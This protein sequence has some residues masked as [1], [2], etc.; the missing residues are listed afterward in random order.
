[1]VRVDGTFASFVR[2]AT[3]ESKPFFYTKWS[4]NGQ[5]KINDMISC[6]E[7]EISAFDIFKT[8]SAFMLIGVGKGPMIAT[9]TTDAPSSQNVTKIATKVAS[10]VSTAVFSFAKTFIWG[11]EQEEKKEPVDPITQVSIKHD[12]SDP[13]REIY[14][15]DADITKRYAV[16]SDHLGRIMILDIQSMTLIH[17]IKGHREA[18]CQW[19]YDG[20]RVWLVVYAPLR[21]ILETYAFEG[22]ITRKH[23]AHVGLEKLMLITP[24]FIG[25][26]SQQ[27][28]P[29]PEL[30]MLS[31]DGTLEKIVLTDPTS[32]NTSP[33][34]PTSPIGEKP[35]SSTDEVLLE[36][37]DTVIKSDTIN[38]KDILDMLTTFKSYSYVIR[39]LDTLLSAPHIPIGLHIEMTQKALSVLF[40]NKDDTVAWQSYKT[41]TENRLILLQ[42]YQTI[43]DHQHFMQQSPQDSDFEFIHEPSEQGWNTD[44]STNHHFDHGSH[45]FKRLPML[46]APQFLQ[47]FHL[48]SQ[49]DSITLDK[50]IGSSKYALANM[51]Y[52]PVITSHDA[53]SIHQMFQ[54]LREISVVPH[55]LQT[56]FMVYM[57][58]CIDAERLIRVP[59]KLVIQ[60]IKFLFQDR[61]SLLVFVSACKRTTHLTN[62]YMI[63]SLLSTHFDEWIRSIPSGR[64]SVDIT[65]GK[66]ENMLYLCSHINLN[67]QVSVSNVEKDTRILGLVAEQQT[68]DDGHGHGK[69]TNLSQD[70]KIE[71]ILKQFPT[72]SGDRYPI[73]IAVYCALN[74]YKMKNYSASFKYIQTM[75]SNVQYECALMIWSK[76]CSEYVA[77]FIEYGI[78]NKRSLKQETT[79]ELYKYQRQLL[80]IMYTHDSLQIEEKEIPKQEWPPQD[81]IL[82]ELEQLSNKYQVS[83]DMVQ[84]MIGFITFM[85][86]VIT[87]DE[88]FD[89][90]SL[91]SVQECL[92]VI[93]HF[94]GTNAHKILA[95]LSQ[96]T[97]HTGQNRLEFIRQLLGHDMVLEAQQLTDANGGFYTMTRDELYVEYVTILYS[98]NRDEEGA[99]QLLKIRD[100]KAKGKAAAALLNIARPR[101]A[102][103]LQKLSKSKQHA[104]WLAEMPPQ[105]FQYF[106]QNVTVTSK[107][108]DLTTS[109]FKARA[110]LENIV[111]LYKI[112]QEENEDYQMAKQLL[113]FVRELANK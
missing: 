61:S 83:K 74:C 8:R 69:H 23:A 34:T 107:D 113:V 91:F 103:I 82:E 51:L 63:L 71:Q 60:L 13:K 109:I 11:T 41:F 108:S 42:V 54:I 87:S 12:L 25:W 106:T 7:T 5:T 16:T 76:F 77:P 96:S 47:C 36:R 68:I 94:A 56:L 89:L 17:I 15:I 97:K 84:Q 80:D 86:V 30:Y 64:A 92:T 67:T 45:P 99:Q 24:P 62:A 110:L 20:D 111:N 75:P 101:F 22:T 81:K 95:R 6:M 39:A 31:L 4:L 70:A 72:F 14:S 28:P 29:R 1:M 27:Y 112:A 2:K 35:T 3:P 52:L 66:L 104:N 93:L 26:N 105:L 90:V 85:Q 98:N 46:S 88:P 33:T 50:S 79:T 9:Y 44:Y 59:P 73:R 40:N 21:G 78:K 18:Q 32:E 58:Q 100:T 53:E 49:S 57:L 55:D 10:K 38:K 19:I 102:F 37:Y 43:S 65:L 48:S